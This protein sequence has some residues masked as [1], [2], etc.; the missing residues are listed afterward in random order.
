MAQKSLSEEGRRTREGRARD[1]HT[2]RAGRAKEGSLVPHARR[3]RRAP[4][5]ASST[6]SA[7]RARAKEHLDETRATKRARVYRTGRDVA[8]TEHALPS[9]LRLFYGSRSAVRK[10]TS[11]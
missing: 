10:T 9:I 2:A 11:L 4:K 5:K 6:T 1:G 7:L 3:R 8:E